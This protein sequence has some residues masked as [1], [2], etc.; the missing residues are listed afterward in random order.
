MAIGFGKHFEIRQGVHVRFRVTVAVEE[1]L[2]LAHH[3]EVAIIE[4]NY[5]DRQMILLAGRKLLNIHLDGAFTRDAGNI[6]IRKG[7][8]AT[9]CIRQANAHG[10]Q[11]A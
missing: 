5:L 8:L 10:A 4:K 9:H 2:P 3:A 11:P 1:L 6:R 7:K